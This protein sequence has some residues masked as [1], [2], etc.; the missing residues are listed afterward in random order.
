MKIDVR[1]RGGKSG[2]KS[3][4]AIS[5]GSTPGKVASAIFGRR[6]DGDVSADENDNT[7]APANDETAEEDEPF[8]IFEAEGSQ[9]VEEIAQETDDQRDD[10]KSSERKVV[11][12]MSEHDGSDHS[13]KAEKS[14]RIAV[15][16]SASTKAL[17]VRPFGGYDKSPR[18]FAE[19]SE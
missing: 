2:K 17:E 16:S 1:K 14:H 7:G 19:K 6:N 11:R 13:A 4:T 18:G 8:A 5:G 12:K 10:G 3:N 15:E 9:S